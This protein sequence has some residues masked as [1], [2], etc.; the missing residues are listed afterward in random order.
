MAIFRGIGGAGDS[1]TDATVTE[2]TQQAVN[3]ANS[4][5]AASTSASSAAASAD[6]A[7][8]AAEN[9]A[10]SA[11]SASNSAS[12]ASDAATAAQTAQTN[13][14]TAETNAES[15]QTAAETAYD[16]FDDRY[17]GSKTSDPSVDND[18]DALI[19]GA[20]YFNTTD[21]VMKVY[22]GT[23]WLAIPVSE[24]YTGTV[25]SVGGTGTVNGLTLTGTVTTSGNL[26]LGGTLSVQDGDIDSETATDG[27]V[28]TA[29]GAGNAAWEA[30]S[31]TGTVTSV[32]ATVPTG[33]TI[34]GSPIISSG[35]L[36]IG[37]DTGYVLPT[38]ASQTNWNTAYGWGDHSTAGYLTS[39]AFGDL[40][41]TPTT[42]SGYGI[43]DAATSAQGAL[44]DSALQPNDNI[45]TLTNDAGY[46]TNAATS[47]Q[48]ALADSA[49]QPN[50]NISTLTNDSGYTTNTGT[51]TSVSGTGT[52]NGLT[53]T[54]TVTTSGDLT[55]GGTLAVQAGDIDSQA[56]T[57]GYVLTADG[58]GNAAWEAA[59]GGGSALELYAENPSS[60]TAPSA[61]GTN[62]VAIGSGA[63]TAA[64]NNGAN[65]ISI[66]GLA[67]TKNQFNLA[68][69]HN[70]E[71]GNILNTGNYAAAV[72]AD[73]VAFAS[74]SFAATKSRAG[75]TDSF[76]AA[77]ANNTSTY[78]ATG[79]SSVAIGDRVK[80]T[81]N[82]SLGIGRLNTVSGPNGAGAI[83]QGLTVSGEGA[84]AAGNNNF[85]SGA[86]SQAFGNAAST[87]SIYGKFAKASGFFNN[88][89]DMQTGMLVVVAATTDATP[90]VLTSNKAAAGTTNQVI[91]P[92]NSAY[93]F[94]GTIIA[95][96][97][98]SAGSDYAAWEI[99]GAILRDGSA[100][101]TV[102]GN[103]IKN[104]LYA[105]AGAAA[106]GVSL[107]ADTTNGGLAI[108]VTGAAATNI[109]WVATVNTSEVT[110]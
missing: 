61:A 16:N 57:D 86:Y 64:G 97:Q 9:A 58:A 66:G 25:T 28:L 65:S 95:R 107:T 33:F 88:Y 49:L 47:A 106:W 44:A 77:I 14:E 40:T 20:L 39:V 81:G 26:T 3:A 36:A 41:S 13:A 52:V 45:S 78:G 80:A 74:Y 50:D 76:A 100:A 98:A 82:Y 12:T 55:L 99:K 2:V 60:P 56:A 11:T 38:T 32:S 63:F 71:A 21:D 15:A 70:T 1:T 68:L 87:Q 110:Y 108:T 103:G 53:L 22:N 51:V 24:T 90:K 75:G 67:E 19:T 94:S 59:G 93:A 27:Y 4:A 42:L 31:G 23:S 79:T 109:R 5:T 48:G 37:F 69:G 73:A 84:F 7:Q 92:N 46:T 104:S 85:A 102:L 62:A 10:N 54:G 105:S 30:V 8:A 83:G 72:G 101:T 35:T 17:L 91:L 29:D 89:A 43:T 34:S 96:E 18:G 6:S